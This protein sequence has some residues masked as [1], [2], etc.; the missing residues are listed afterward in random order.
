MPLPEALEDYGLCI[1]LG[2]HT[3]QARSRDELNRVLEVLVVWRRNE[4]N[5]AGVSHTL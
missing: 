1:L 2:I 5:F 4:V 3:R